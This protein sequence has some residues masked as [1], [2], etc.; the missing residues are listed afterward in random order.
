MEFI[1]RVIPP[2]NVLV[3]FVRSYGQTT[4]ERSPLLLRNPR[5]LG[6]QDQYL[7]HSVSIHVAF[8]GNAPDLLQ[9]ESS[10]GQV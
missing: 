10:D 5:A 6:W 8:S 3:M 9:N 2:V 7:V 1:G 4:L